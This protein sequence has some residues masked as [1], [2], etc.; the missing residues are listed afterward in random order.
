MV[1]VC[2]D[3][4]RY[5]KFIMSVWVTRGG[6][7]SLKYATRV[8]NRLSHCLSD[9][10]T[11][12]GLVARKT[13]FA[14][15]EQQRHRPACACADQSM[16]QEV[17]TPLENYKNIGFLSKTGPDPLKVWVQRS[18]IDTI[19]HHIRPRIPMGK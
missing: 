3:F 16:G 6:L 8:I 7:N 13:D 5:I 11:S 10:F 12:M 17:R 1:Y 19:K 9:L 2:K 15:C 4:N 14:A 18:G